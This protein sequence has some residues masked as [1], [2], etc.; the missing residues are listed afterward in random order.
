VGFDADGGLICDPINFPPIAKAQADP[1]AG[2]VD[3]A[4]AFDG[5]GSFDL[6]GDLPLSFN[7]NF[8]DGESSS[9]ES[10]MHAFTDP[11]I[12][13]VTLIV[14][15]F[16][17]A[18]SEA[19]LA[20]EVSDQPPTP[21]AHGDLV[22]SEIMKDPSALSETVGEYFEIFNPTATP[23]TLFGCIISD[24][25]ID[26]HEIPEE[27]VIKPRAY[28]TLAVS[29]AAVP[30]PDYVYRS[31]IPPSLTFFLD[32]NE[33]E[34]ILTCNGTVIDEVAYD[35]SFPNVSGASMNLDPDAL[36]AEDNDFGINWCDTPPDADILD[37]SDVGTPG[38]LN[39]TCP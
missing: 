11:G 7:W 30:N 3:F 27:V 25:G 36:D 10:P 33:D 18:S 12:Y 15:D 34:V 4:I 28:A 32:N 23:F 38:A 17:G 6:D 22:I 20:V 21:T 1:S 31:P 26:F 16:R 14:T 37:S 19:S 35:S 5:S 29:A 39:G 8:G 2:V 9:D 13:T 24:D